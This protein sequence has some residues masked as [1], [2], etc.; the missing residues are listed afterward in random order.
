MSYDIFESV[1]PVTAAD[2]FQFTESRNATHV[3]GS[4]IDLSLES[5]AA[6]E[7]SIINQFNDF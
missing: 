6:Q 7:P 3:D 1:T 2:P 5:R 4:G